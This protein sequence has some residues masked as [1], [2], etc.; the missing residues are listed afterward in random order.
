MKKRDIST[1]AV[2]VNPCYSCPF[3]GKEPV[4]LHPDKLAYYYDN[5]LNQ[6]GQHICHSV[7]RTI[8]RGGRIIQL[9]WFTAIGLLPEPTDEAFNQ[10]VINAQKS[11]HKDDL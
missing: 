3:A 8:C 7:K 9:Q 2:A 11:T 1:Y 4:E 10:A 5:L 6:G